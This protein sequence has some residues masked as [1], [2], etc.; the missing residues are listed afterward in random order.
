VKVGGKQNKTTT[1]KQNPAYSIHNPYPTPL[2]KTKTK[3][4]PNQTEILFLFLY[5]P[6]ERG[7]QVPL[8]FDLRANIITVIKHFMDM[9]SCRKNNDN[10]PQ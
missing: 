10:Y 3:E 8:P 2:K 9:K 1:Q 5:S 6:M 7:L 4:R